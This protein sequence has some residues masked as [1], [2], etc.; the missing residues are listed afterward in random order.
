MQNAEHGFWRNPAFWI[1]IIL[2]AMPFMLLVDVFYIH[3]DAYESELR[4][5]VV[6]GVLAVIM[7]V[8]GFWIGSSIGSLKKDDALL[9]Q[10]NQ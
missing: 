7:M 5:Q 4:T 10:R 9:Q 1:S 8:G 3:P 2:L 6:T